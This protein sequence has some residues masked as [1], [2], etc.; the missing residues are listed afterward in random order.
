MGTHQTMVFETKTQMVTAQRSLA[1]Q[2]MAAVRLVTQPVRRDGASP[3]ALPTWDANT[4]KLRQRR[5]MTPIHLQ[6]PRPCLAHVFV[7]SLQ[8]GNVSTEHHP[9]RH[10]RRSSLYL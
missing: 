6:Q 7:R 10:L 2:P 4:C 8:Y 3:Q 1:S 5:R 9:C